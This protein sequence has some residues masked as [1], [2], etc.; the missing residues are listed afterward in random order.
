MMILTSRWFWLLLLSG[1]F[2]LLQLWSGVQYGDAPRNLHWALL[3]VENPK[4]LLDAPDPYSRIDGFVPDPPELAPRGEVFE[5]QSTF[6]PWWGPVPVLLMAG[7]W[8]LTGSQTLMTLVVPVAAGGSV[9]ACYGL[10][11]WLFDRRTGLLAAAVVALW[12][13]FYQNAVISYS[14]AISTLFLMLALWAY[15]RSHV[16]LTVL[17][18]AIT[19]LCKMDMAV[20]YGGVVGCSLL[21]RLYHRMDR[22]LIVHSLL[23]LL[24]PGLLL[25]VWY[26][27]RTGFPLPMG[28]G[29]GLSLDIFRLVA[30]DMLQGFFFIPWYGSILTL[31]VVGVGV[32]PGL[33]SPRLD[34]EKRLIL[35][36]WVGLGLFVL[37]VYMLTPG[38]GNTPR[39]IM[40]S[41]PA[42][43]LLAVE[44]WQ[45]LPRLW[46]R[47]VA[48]YMSVLLIIT[49]AFVAYFIM[50]HRPFLEAHRDVWQFLRE[51]P[52]GF[53]LIAEPWV[54]LWHTRQPVT[55]F[56]GDIE[57]QENILHNREHFIH[58]T[59]QHP[60]RY[61]PVP[62]PQGVAAIE[63]SAFNVNAQGLYADEVVAY[64]RVHAR[65]VALPP[66][67]DV[68]ILPLE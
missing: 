42:V 66:Y 54:T 23:A 6:H 28:T 64:L 35:G 20:L 49:S 55:W 9:L 12:P 24:L 32:V 14:E 25:M 21:Y 59:T 37:L 65:Q 30:L 67:Y 45:R 5:Q 15:L 29:K 56:E 31:G 34:S 18:G 48:L 8:W 39:V 43:A 58:Y 40:P 52:R 16:V 62:R 63:R 19:L 26:W 38:A 41:L 27:L 10:G 50:A 4:F 53:V 13:L 61:V 60:I 17:L 44:G 68:Y 51:Q 3:T 47:R 33:R 22:R 7:V 36:S 2:V 46:L 1:Q 11:S 57:F